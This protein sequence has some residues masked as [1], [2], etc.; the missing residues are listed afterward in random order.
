[1]PAPKPGTV[2]DWDTSNLNLAMPSGGQIASGWT[3]DQVVPSN[4]LNWF[5]NLVGQW[6]DYLRD[7]EI[8]AHTW[9]VTQTFTPTAAS[10]AVV[11]NGN[12]SAPAVLG[13]G[14][15]GP[16]IEGKGGTAG[17][18]NAA[19][20][21]GIA[22]TGVNEPG[23]YGSGNDGTGAGVYGE[24]GSGGGPGVYGECS[25]ASA[26]G[27]QFAANGVFGAVNLIPG[28]APST[29]PAGD[30]WVDNSVPQLGVRL[31]AAGTDPNKNGVTLGP[32][33]WSRAAGHIT[34]NGSGAAVLDDGVGFGAITPFNGPNEITINWAK[35]FASAKSYAVFLSCDNPGGSTLYMPLI[36][37]KTA[38]AI[39]VKIVQ[40]TLGSPANLVDQDPT[41]TANLGLSV[42]AQGITT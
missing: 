22:H 21:F 28:A 8:Q 9:T 33:N 12:G 42:I 25:A 2:A 27:G 40:V 34:T 17:G 39:Q 32:K 7:F 16:G 24:G 23:V 6:T 31:G 35:Q 26:Q 13:N 29:P 11:A 10:S 36:L 30:M 19:G 18:V 38:T 20:V 41:T 1:M 4:W 5:M 37:S 14:G 15:T 3:V